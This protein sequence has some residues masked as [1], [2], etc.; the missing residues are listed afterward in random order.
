MNR[1]CPKRKLSVR[2][3]RT[4]KTWD[5]STPTSRGQLRLDI[6][7]LNKQSQKD[8]NQRIKTT[9]PRKITRRGKFSPSWRVHQAQRWTKAISSSKAPFSFR[10]RS[11][12][13]RSWA[14]SRVNLL[15]RFSGRVR[16]VVGSSRRKSKRPRRATRCHL[17]RLSVPST[18][19][20]NFNRL[21]TLRS[22]NWSPTPIPER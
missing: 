12:T 5:R 2:I 16:M 4:S 22:R 15:L 13:R 9:R 7:M 8:W 11:M 10:R 21:H 18:W 3:S 6:H 17:S 20:H 19:F 1:N 14:I